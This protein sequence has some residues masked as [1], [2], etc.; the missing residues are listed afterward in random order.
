MVA[1]VM[2][3]AQTAHAHIDLDQ[4]G[5]THESRYGAAAIKDG[6]CGQAGGTRGDNVYE[7]KPGSTIEIKVSEFVQHPGYFRIAF[8]DDG[9]DSFVT[10]VSI[11]GEHGD[12]GGDPKCGPGMEDFCNND[13]VLIDNLD[14]HASEGIFAPAKDWTWKVKLP[15]VECDN[16]TLQIIQVMTD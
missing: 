16:C 9:D 11:T 10:P 4:A 6:P 15:N 1:G 7:Y 12:C 3:V 2:L 5:G 8:D 13:T 14:P